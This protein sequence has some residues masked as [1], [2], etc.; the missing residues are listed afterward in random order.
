[1]LKAYKTEINPTGEQRLQ[2]SK[3]IGVCRY[4]YNLYISRNKEAYENGE[5]FISAYDFDKWI[6][7]VFSR[8]EEYKW[9]K[10]VSSKARKQAICNAESAFK[11]FFKGLSGFP[12]YKKKKNQDVS[13]YFPKNNKGDL[14]LDR[15][16]I[17]V[18]TLGYVKLK[19]KGYIP[20]KSNVVN[21]TISKKAD[22]YFISVLIDT[23]DNS[24][25]K[26]VG[27]E[28]SGIGVDVGVKEFAVVSNGKFYKNINKTGKVRKLNKRLKHIQRS[29]NRKYR[30]NKTKGVKG[31]TKNTNRQILKLQRLHKRIAD[32]R[33]DYVYK[34]VDELVKTKPDYITIENLNIQGMK[35]NKHLAR[36]ISEQNFGLFTM[37]LRSKCEKYGTELRRVSKFYPSSK[38]CHRCGF[39][40]KDLKLSDRVYKC[41]NC[42]LEIDRDLNSSIN[43]SRAGTYEILVP[44][45]GRELKPP[46]CYTNSSS[47]DEAGHNE[48][49]T[50]LV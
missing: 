7:N 9:I 14:L 44:M 10:E 48:R 15:H 38:T 4:L 47:F 5:K 18:P 49:G 27:K 39:Y 31:A 23:T 42:G 3:T 43:L 37:L 36:A 35:K 29:I 50:L 22:R 40:K 13:I 19:E 16:R 2:I 25:V 34:V 21:C 41:E 1:M 45:A 17:K 6:N 26:A 11:R 32:I 28:T 46:E 24:K 30:T 8:E 12:V 33:H 20:V